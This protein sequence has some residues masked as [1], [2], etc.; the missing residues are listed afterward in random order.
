MDNSKYRISSIL[1]SQIIGVS[2]KGIQAFFVSNLEISD[3][4]QY[5]ANNPLRLGKEIEKVFSACVK[6]SLNYQVIKENIQILQGKITIG[7]LDFILKNTTSNQ[8][9]HLELVY[10]FYVYDSK[11]SINEI[12]RWVGPNRKD[13]LIEKLNKIEIKQFPLLQNPLTQLKLEGIDVSKMKQNLCFMANLFVPYQK[14][15]NYFTEIN[16]KAISGYWL[17]L[18]DF[19]NL[20]DSKNL[21]YLPP[22]S[23]WGVDPKYNLTWLTKPEVINQITEQHQRQFSP[24][25]WVKRLNIKFEQCFV[26]WW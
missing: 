14:Q 22:K 13:S 16:N 11:Q 4:I 18:V 1:N 17:S 25:C 9:I 2:P 19:S 23:E 12:E 7:E 3:P 15:N 26:V 21:Y 8:Y 24:L 5:K 6:A 10:K 20:L